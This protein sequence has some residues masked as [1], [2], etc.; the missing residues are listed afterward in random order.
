MFATSGRISFH[1]TRRRISGCRAAA[2]FWERCAIWLPFRLLAVS[3]SDQDNILVWSHLHTFNP[4]SYP[5]AV[6]APGRAWLGWAD[7]ILA[8]IGLR[9]L[10]R[11]RNHQSTGSHNTPFARIDNPVGIWRTG[12]NQ[13]AGC[14]GAF[15]HSIW[16]R[17]VRLAIPG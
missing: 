17:D 11:S 13:P 6:L 10:L 12:R 1:G 9:P 16:W 15:Q 2:I 8:V 14:P 5:A 3:R 7:G 4:K